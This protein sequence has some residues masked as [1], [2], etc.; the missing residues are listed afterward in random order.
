MP[1]QK[2]NK[3][4]IAVIGVL[5]VIATAVFSNWDKFFDG[6]EEVR[7]NYTGYQEIG[8]FDAEVRYLIE[9]AGIRLTYESMQKEIE[10]KFIE[11]LMTAHPDDEERI[12]ELL[13]T[14]AGEV[15]DSD[16]LIAELLPVYRKLYTIEEVQELNRFYSTEVMQKHVKKFL[17]WC[18][19]FLLYEQ[20]IL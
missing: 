3:V 12:N 10:D 7:A 14:F 18:T 9:A 5:G 19:N 13:N 6:I 11:G 20:G 17:M 1:E 16:A 2:N 8:V 4:L 15:M